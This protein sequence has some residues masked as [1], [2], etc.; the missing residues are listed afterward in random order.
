MRGA[1]TRY[2]LGAFEPV[3]MVHISLDKRAAFSSAGAMQR[4]SMLDGWCCSHRTLKV[5]VPRLQSSDDREP[6]L[7]FS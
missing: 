4:I 7:V 5:R 3:A 1:G 2:C 6:F